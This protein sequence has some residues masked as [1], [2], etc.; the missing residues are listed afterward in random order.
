LKQGP[1]E[2]VIIEQAIRGRKPLPDAIANSPDLFEGLELYYVAF[3]DLTSSRAFGASEGPIPWMPIDYYC[4]TKGFSEEQRD[5][6]F[7][8]ITAM[9]KA[10]LDYRGEKSK[11]TIKKPSKLGSKKG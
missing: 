10:Y 6:A 2:K 8:F 4:R 5:D 7:H 9:D 11:A 3:L 1:T